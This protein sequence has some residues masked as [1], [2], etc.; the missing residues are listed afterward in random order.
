M[1]K[2]LFLAISFFLYSLE[3]TE[4]AF[5]ATIMDK[6]KLHKSSSASSFCSGP[7]GVVGKIQKGDS[8]KL[9]SLLQ[10][11]NI[12]C[13]SLSLIPVI[14][15]SEG[16]DV[17][18]AILI[19][20]LIRS[21]ELWTE[22]SS[23]YKCYSACI[24]AFSGGVYRSPYG[25]MGIHRPYFVAI[26]SALSIKAIKELR[27]V[28]SQKLR[29]YFNEMDINGALVDAMMA[30]PPESIK[31]L[32]S[33]ELVSFRLEGIDANYDEKVIATLAKRF[34]TT[35][36]VMRKR[37]IAGFKCDV[38]DFDCREAAYWGV[39]LDTYKHRFE[40]YTQVCKVNTFAELEKCKI[41]IMNGYRR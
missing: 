14:F 17:D 35:S 21:H 1:L 29:E 22:V 4:K 34:G 2:L 31:I 11:L 32:S 7:V 6:T 19:G 13:G 25:K 8:E 36:A 40:R 18:E 24:L 39:S 23:D 12:K 26:D 41:D 20:Q 9:K 15:H 38:S 16:G 37:Q 5:S 30:I 28:R 27:D 33:A 3:I 10:D